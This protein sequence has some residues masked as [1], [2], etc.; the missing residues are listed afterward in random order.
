MPHLANQRSYTLRTTRIPSVIPSDQCPVITLG[1]LQ[2]EC[3]VLYNKPVPAPVY[4]AT[5]CATSPTMKDHVVLNP[6]HGAGDDDVLQTRTIVGGAVIVRTQFYW[7][8]YPTGPTAGY[9]APV[10]RWMETTITGLTQ[11]PIVLQ[12]SYA[13]TYVP[14]HH[15][16]WETFLFEPRLDPSV[17]PGILA[18]LEAGGAGRIMAFTDGPGG[19]C[20]YDSYGDN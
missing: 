16:F 5:L 1:D 19:I 12:S 6:C 11:T 14:G 15:N 10:V 20:T 13:Q 4:G 17:P 18:E 9:T 7:P 3:D 8:P 2:F